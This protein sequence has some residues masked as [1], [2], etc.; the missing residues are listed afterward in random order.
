MPKRYRHEIWGRHPWALF[1]I[2]GSAIVIIRYVDLHAVF[3]RRRVPAFSLFS[4]W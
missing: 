4:R 3:R 2:A 1:M